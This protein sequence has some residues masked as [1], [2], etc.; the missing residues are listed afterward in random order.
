MTSNIT[1]IQPMDN[2]PMFAP[3]FPSQTEG[4]VL[5][6]GRKSTLDLYRID[7]FKQ[8]LKDNNAQL[9]DTAGNNLVLVFG[10]GSVETK[11]TM[12]VGKRN[13]NVVLR[14]DS[15]NYGIRTDNED[16]TINLGGHHAHIPY[17]FF[18]EDIIKQCIDAQPG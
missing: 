10:D 14:H 15:Y 6:L 11:T 4:N 7:E 12:S 2:A 3:A 18:S 8:Y 5:H 16:V 13:V 1:N 9:I 17:R